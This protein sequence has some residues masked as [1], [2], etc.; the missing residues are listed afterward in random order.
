MVWAIAATTTY[1]VLQ[2]ILHVRR[3]LARPGHPAVVYSA[4]FTAHSRGRY[5]A[6]PAITVGPVQPAAKWRGDIR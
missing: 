6:A 2:R 5:A 4:A 1:T 3:Q